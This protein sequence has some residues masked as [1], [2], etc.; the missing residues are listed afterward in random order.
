MKYFVKLLLIFCFVEVSAE[1]ERNFII[2][3]NVGYSYDYEDISENIT[4]GFFQTVDREIR[5]FDFSLSVGRKFGSDFYYGLGFGL[6]FWKEAWNPDLNKPDQNYV[7][8]WASLRKDYVY[9]PLAYL[10]YVAN[11]VERAQVTLTLISRYDFEKSIEESTLFEPWTLVGGGH[12]FLTRTSGKEST[13]QYFN[14]GLVPGFR[15]NLSKTFGLNIAFGSLVYRVKTAESK[16]SDL[17]FK[18]AREFNM[19]FHPENW[20]VGFHFIF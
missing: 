5:D 2:I 3:S 13:R 10:Q 6:N 17:D 7:H 12:T 15:V 18:K 16:L 14:A 4:S 9:S 8:G 20:R 11:L 19:R 1:T